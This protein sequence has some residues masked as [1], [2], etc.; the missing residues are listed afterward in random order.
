ML[1][2]SELEL[3][4]RLTWLLNRDGVPRFLSGVA[5]FWVEVA[6][7]AY[8]ESGFRNVANDDSIRILLELPR[9]V[10]RSL[11]FFPENVPHAILRPLVAQHERGVGG[12]ARDEAKTPDPVR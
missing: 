11:R 2:V 1:V 4:E 7:W 8:V 6:A 5:E 9:W 10:H 3:T 12:V